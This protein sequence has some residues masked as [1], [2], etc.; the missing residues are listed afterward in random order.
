M[1][2]D[3]CHSHG[4]GVS[5]QKAY[6]LLFDLLEGHLPTETEKRVRAHFGACPP[7][8]EFLES[9]RKTPHLCRQ[10]L[11]KEV[12]D[13]VTQSLLGFLRRQLPQKAK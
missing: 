1:S 3:Q 9:Y 4:D 11:A 2:E 13:E 7:C 10:A 6:D 8:L 5:C 12:P